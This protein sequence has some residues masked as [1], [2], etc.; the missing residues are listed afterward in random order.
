[1]IVQFNGTPELLEDV[2][3]KNFIVDLQRSSTRGSPVW[4]A[5]NNDK[6]STENIHR[7]MSHLKW[8]HV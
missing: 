4:Q 6:A 8:S 7:V 2:S 3:T 5:I 1:M